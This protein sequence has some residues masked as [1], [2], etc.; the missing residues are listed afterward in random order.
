MDGAGFF[1]PGEAGDFLSTA[2]ETFSRN[3]PKKKEKARGPF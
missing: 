3:I 2:Q 1:I